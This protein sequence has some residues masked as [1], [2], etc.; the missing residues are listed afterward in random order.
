M[1]KSM[2]RWEGVCI[3]IWVDVLMFWVDVLFCSDVLFWVNLLFC[4][5][6]LPQLDA[7]SAAWCIFCC[8]VHATRRT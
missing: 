1:V 8:M 6:V 3:N 2:S 5:E 7:L 4:S